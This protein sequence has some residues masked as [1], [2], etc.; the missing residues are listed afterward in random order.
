MF[1]ILIQISLQFLP[2]GPIDKMSAWVQV[3]FGAKPLYEPKVI[4]F[5][6]AYMY[7]QTSMS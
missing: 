3:M 5:I 6:D 1:C 4:P 2:N 7:P